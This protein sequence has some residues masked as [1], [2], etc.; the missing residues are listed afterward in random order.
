MP[1]YVAHE[2]LRAEGLTDVRYVAGGDGDSLQWLARGDLDFDWNFAAMHIAS[3]EAGVPVTVLAGMHSGCLELIANER[4]QSI[5][6]SRARKSAS[7]VSVRART[8]WSR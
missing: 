5:A 3:I 1:E 8:S 6:D 7:M 4:V 2:L